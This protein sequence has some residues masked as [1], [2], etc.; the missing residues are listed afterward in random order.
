MD[1]G[2]LIGILFSLQEQNKELLNMVMN[3][4]V[5]NNQLKE[6]L[7]SELYKVYEEMYNLK[8]PAEVKDFLESKK[9]IV[10]ELNDIAQKESAKAIEKFNENFAVMEETLETILTLK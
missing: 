9:F 4:Q 1:E 6:Q 2:K 8:E 5:A 10:G 3:L 7:N